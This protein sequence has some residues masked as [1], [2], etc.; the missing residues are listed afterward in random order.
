M[1]PALLA[2]SMLEQ[3][4]A[5][6]NTASSRDHPAID[7]APESRAGLTL[8]VS[9]QH[10]RFD[11]CMDTPAAPTSVAE[12]EEQRP[13]LD[14]VASFSVSDLQVTSSITPS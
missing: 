11:F 6:Q 14:A 9:S 7:S 4:C 8:M 3:L 5:V 10:L 2:V 1:S 12:R 13:L